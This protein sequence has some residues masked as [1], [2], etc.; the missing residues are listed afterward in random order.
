MI[1]ARVGVVK[2]TKNVMVRSEIKKHVA[3]QRPN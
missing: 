1:P 2:S 3:E